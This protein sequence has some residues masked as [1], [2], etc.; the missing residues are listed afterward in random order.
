MSSYIFRIPVISLLTTERS[1]EFVIPHSKIVYH[2]ASLF[3]EAVPTR[4]GVSGVTTRPELLAAGREV[5]GE[6]GGGQQ[7]RI[8]VCKLSSGP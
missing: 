3:L 5:R 1:C 4:I 6:G 7:S 2:P 8:L